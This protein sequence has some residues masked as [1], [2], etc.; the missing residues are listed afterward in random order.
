MSARAT[1]CGQRRGVTA[2]RRGARGLAVAGL[3]GLAGCGGGSATSDA[4]SGAEAAAATMASDCGGSE[5]DWQTLIEAAQGEEKVVTS[6]PAQPETRKQIPGEFEKQFGIGVDYLAGRSSELV[7]KLQSERAAGIYSLD[8]FIGGANS[9][10]TVVY[11]N[12]WLGDLEAAFVSPGITDPATYSNNEVPF[13]DPEGSRILALA[14]TATPGIVVNTDLVQDGE[15]TGFDDLLDPRWKGKIVSDDPA[16]P[17]G[18][19][20]NLGVQLVMEKGD[21]FF[22]DL[23]VGQEVTLMT[24]A[25][26]E[27]DGVAQGKWA[28]GLA[29]EPNQVGLDEMREDGLPIAAIHADDLESTVSSGNGLL[30]LMADA[31]HPN[32]AKLFANWLACPA[33]NA[34][35]ARSQGYSSLRSDVTVDVPETTTFDPAET[36]WDLYRWDLV[37]GDDI[38]QLHDEI[39]SE[40][41]K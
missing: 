31:P 7:P 16:A 36:Y 32:A 41:A 18:Y 5:A 8:T 22:R 34:V 14:V 6:G 13:K 38:N 39:K 2:G 35:W 37:T 33:G 10:Y 19:G 23:Y 26:Q 27:A 30:G 20:V 25:R 3:L 12:D 1:A 9:M 29:I 15:I 28:I 11:A 17:A 24:D 21:D 40:L 4:G